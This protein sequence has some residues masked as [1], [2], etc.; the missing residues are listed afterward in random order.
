MDID[1]E[2]IR[3]ARATLA[4]PGVPAFSSLAE[5]LRHTDADAVLCVVPPAHHEPI[6]V[7]ALEA[8]LHVLSEKPIADTLDACH[9]IVRARGPAAGR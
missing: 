4:Q 5:A 1:P 2:A 7:G 3:T 8:G 9:R 6:V